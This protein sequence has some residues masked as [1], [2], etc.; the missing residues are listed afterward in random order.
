MIVINYILK[1][2]ICFISFIETDSNLDPML[3]EREVKSNAGNL[4][5]LFLFLIGVAE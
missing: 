3:E 2:V 5:I 1:V 4:V